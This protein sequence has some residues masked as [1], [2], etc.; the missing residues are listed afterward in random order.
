MYN[1]LSDDYWNC[2][3]N[4]NT[5]VKDNNYYPA[6]MLLNISNENI[7]I[8]KR[9]KKKTRIIKG[10]TTFEI[11]LINKDILTKSIWYLIN[12]PTDKTTNKNIKN[13]YQIN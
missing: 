5:T 10:N 7:Q 3:K 11:V 6:W 12:E 4:I 9:D 2:N 1:R 13:F 8:W